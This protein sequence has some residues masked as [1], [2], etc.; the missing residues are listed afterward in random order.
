MYSL[1]DIYVVAKFFM[2]KAPDG[3]MHC[4]SRTLGK[5]SIIDHE[6]AGNVKNREI[7]VCQIIREIHP[8][9][10][11]GA[12]IL[13]PVKRIPDPETMIRKIIPGF[14]KTEVVNNKT[15]LII[16]NTDPGDYWMLS[17]ATR[18]IFSKK[19]YSV[20]V[21]IAYSEYAHGSIDEGTENASQSKEEPADN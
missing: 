8:G 14:Y 10:N 1:K 18:Q 20:I 21:P 13:R 9:Q 19:F 15:A 4:I 16:P 5:F 3:S 7:W 12:F 2:S 6:Y 17:K 11:K